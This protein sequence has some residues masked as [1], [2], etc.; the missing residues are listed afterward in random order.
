M[1][2]VKRVA[3]RRIA[4]NAATYLVLA[5]G[6]VVTVGPYLLSLLTSMKTPR[7]FGSQTSPLAFP[8]PFTLSNYS[9][10]FSGE[11]GFV[12]PLVVTVQMVA[13]ILVGQLLCSVLAAYAF[14]RLRFPG[15]DALFWVYLSTLMVPQIVTL[16]PLYTMMAQAGLRN[17]FWGLVL[18]TV[19]GSPYAIFLLR[20][21]FRG[22]PGELID[23]A[24]VD[25]A[26]TPRVLWHVVV[27]MSR[28]ILATLTIITIVTHWNNFLWPLIITTGPTWQ[29]LTVAT[30][31]LQGQ[32]NGNWTLVTAAT[33]VAMAPLVLLFL[34]FQR[35]VVR[36]IS[37]TGMKS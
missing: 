26:G 19:F 33:T 24:R 11:Y 29:V 7:Q 5:A 20:E 22:I 37:L 10:L 9:G 8:S 1:N 3:G 14:A 30:A 16:V 12:T 28:P 34:L 18:P 13:V 27:P 35:H 36:S 4:G 23:A 6:A 2:S 25:G 17:T 31:N 21:Y 32:Y 15:R